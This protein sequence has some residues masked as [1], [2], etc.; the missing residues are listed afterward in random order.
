MTRHV[1][2]KP[3][4]RKPGSRMREYLRVE[5]TDGLQQATRKLHARSLGDRG[6]AR[7][8][9]YLRIDRGHEA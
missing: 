7:L 2:D 6:E 1:I 4:E 9:H 8:Q 5:R 3:S